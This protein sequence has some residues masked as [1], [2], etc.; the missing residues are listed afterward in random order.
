MENLEIW[1]KVCKTDPA[2]TKKAKKGQYH[3]T[4]IAPVYQFKMATEVFGP[5]GLGWGVVV[6]SETFTEQQFDTTT[7]LSYDAVMFFTVDGK[8]GEIPIHASEKSCYKTQ[9][10]NGYMKVDDEARK[11]VV[12]NAKTKGLSELGFN[13]DVFMGQHDNS[14]YLEVVAN[15]FA[16]EKAEDKLEEKARQE[17][18]YKEWLAVSLNTIGKCGTMSELRGAYQS[19]VRKANLTDD[20]AAI[21]SFT[22]AKDARK[23]E[24]ENDA[25]VSDN[26]AA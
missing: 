16:L 17:Q 10:E 14:D 20:K 22:K 12:T 2:Y 4:S 5:Q 24:L 26:R 6:G 3:F 13:A 8:R 7:I 21:Q 9:G 11:K 15:E 18:Q 19:L 23:E 25:P 1:D